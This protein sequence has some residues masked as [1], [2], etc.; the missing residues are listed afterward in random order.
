[1]N[2][3]K[4]PDVLFTADALMKKGGVTEATKEL[5]LEAKCPDG[6]AV[7]ATITVPKVRTN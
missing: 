2:G 6:T 4:F 3:D 7:S 1:M 5:T